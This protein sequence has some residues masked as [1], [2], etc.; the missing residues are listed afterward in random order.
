MPKTPIDYSKCCIY[1]ICCKDPSI[2]EIYVGSTTEI[3]KRRWNHKS[4]CNDPNSK[5]HNYNVYKF[6]RENGGWD[7]WDMVRIESFPCESSEEV[8]Q[9]EREVFDELKPTLNIRRPKISNEEILEEAR[10]RNKALYAV[11]PEKNRAKNKAWYAANQEKSRAASKAW[12]AANPEKH[13]AASKAWNAA[14]PEKH[15]A[16]K[17]AWSTE[18]VVCEHCNKEVSRGN[19]RVHQRTKKCVAAQNAANITAPLEDPPAAR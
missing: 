16:N 18:K 11:N 5:E 6:I 4:K 7:N 12:N 17:K 14:N 1:K 9:R 15:R 2:N 8:R 3:V 10:A 19:L 13:R